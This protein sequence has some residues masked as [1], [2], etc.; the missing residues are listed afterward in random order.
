M[1]PETREYL[2]AR[3]GPQFVSGNPGGDHLKA[4]RAAFG[5]VSV[6]V[7]NDED[8]AVHVLDRAETIRL[9]DWL[10]TYLD[11]RPTPKASPAPPGTTVEPTSADDWVW[12]CD[13]RDCS[14]ELEPG[15]WYGTATGGFS[16]EL[17]ARQG[18]AAHLAEEHPTQVGG[19][20]TP[21]ET[22][23]PTKD[24]T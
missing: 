20:P 4:T 7:D 24:N 19:W 3:R 10:T 16:S 22:P 14:T 17:A 18:L 9:R 13:H 8:L 15:L 21:N 1:R 5:G 11:S 2:R 12:T 23:P 6:T